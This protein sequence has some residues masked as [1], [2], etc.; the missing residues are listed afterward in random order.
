MVI[1]KDFRF[2][3]FFV[4]S[5]F[6]RRLVYRHLIDIW[7]VVDLLQCGII[8]R[9]VAILYLYLD[10]DRQNIFDRLIIQTVKNIKL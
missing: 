4:L 5:S 2:Y 8:D 6:Y 3:L 1:H 10:S 9:F 7:F